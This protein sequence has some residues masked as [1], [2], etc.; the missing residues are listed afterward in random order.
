MRRAPSQEEHG[1]GTHLLGLLGGASGV[2][3]CSL[4]GGGKGVHI[5]SPLR[6][7]G[8]PEGRRPVQSL[9]RGTAIGIETVLRPQAV[10]ASGNHLRGWVRD[11]GAE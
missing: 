3:G 5:Q 2:P 10:E 9:L 11:Y 8:S 7:I 4:H 6:V 1:E